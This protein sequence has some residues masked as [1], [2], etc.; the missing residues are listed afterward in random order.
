MSSS[1]RDAV[2]IVG[3]GAVLPDAP[4]A[5]TFWGNVKGGRYSVTEVPPD[6]WDVGLYYDPD[7][8]TFDY[9]MLRTAGVDPV[10][11]VATES[12]DTY[13]SRELDLVWK[14]DASEAGTS[15]TYE[16]VADDS[17]APALKKNIVINVK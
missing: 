5:A 17:T 6:R 1:A 8:G 7:P 4:D 11:Y 14:T 10:N 12:G 3:V 2:A 16:L 15:A 9:S 13:T